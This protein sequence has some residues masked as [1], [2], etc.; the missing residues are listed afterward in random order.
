M[1][2]LLLEMAAAMISLLPKVPFLILALFCFAVGI[3][4]S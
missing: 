4:A 2:F 1:I 3:R